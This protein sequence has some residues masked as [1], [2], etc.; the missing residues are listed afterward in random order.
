MLAAGALVSAAT[1]AP[2]EPAA[3][4]HLLHAL[5]TLE[6]ATAT[7]S[8]SAPMRLAL[9][10][11][12]TLLVR[13]AAVVPPALVLHWCFSQV[14]KPQCIAASCVYAV[15]VLRASTVTSCLFL[16]SFLTA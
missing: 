14:R 10:G 8:W 7:R 9:V 1:L 13:P 4:R 12:H 11:L 2:S 5:L 3:A 16:A 15:H 6:A